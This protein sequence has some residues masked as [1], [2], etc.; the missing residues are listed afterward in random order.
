M[1]RLDELDKQI[2]YFDSMAAEFQSKSYSAKEEYAKL[3]AKLKK[4]SDEE[5]TILEGLGFLCTGDGEG[6]AFELSFRGSVEYILQ[7]DSSKAYFL[8]KGPYETVSVCGT[9][10]GAL[11]C[12]AE[13]I[14]LD[15]ASIEGKRDYLLTNRDFLKEVISKVR[16]AEDER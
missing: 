7:K 3:S 4:W 13:H 9:F 14:K 2:A 5:I 1:D 12:L 8:L 6:S 10:D 16:G 11:E 15:V